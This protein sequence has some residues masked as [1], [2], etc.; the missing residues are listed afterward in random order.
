MNMSNVKKWI[1]RIAFDFVLICG[2]LY[3]I[4]FSVCA[5][6][7][8]SVM[9][10]P[11]KAEY[12]WQTP[13]IINIGDAKEPIAAYW[14]PHPGASNVILYSHGNGEDIGDLSGVFQTISE[15]GISILAFDYPGYGLSDG[16]PTEMGCYASAEKAYQFL[17]LTQHVSPDRILVL[18]RSLGA[19]TACYLAEKYPVAGL[20][21]ESGFLS[22]PRVVTRVR[23]L[24]F[25]PFPNIR[26]IKRISCPK[27]FLHGTQDSVIP[28]W[29]G[30]KMYELSPDPKRHMWVNGGGHDDL[31]YVFGG[32]RYRSL[33]KK[34]TETKHVSN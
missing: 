32:N 15:A 17:T 29:H 6:K 18:G 11:H 16:R 5:F 23:L 33:I 28:F 22:A 10:Y 13:N 2:G 12:T 21:F 26:R 27:L 14:L 20:I 9:F 3:L 34:F 25:D 30:Q 31:V 24:P 4:A 19:G 7:I 8:N 1:R